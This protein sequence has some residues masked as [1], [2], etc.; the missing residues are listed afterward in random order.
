MRR[1]FLAIWVL[2]LVGALLA[3]TDVWVDRG[4]VGAGIEVVTIIPGTP[5]TLL[6]GNAAGLLRSTDG[7]VSWEEG[8][9]G[10][11][12]AAVIDLDVDPDATATVWATT[13]EGLYRSADGGDTWTAVRYWSISFYMTR[14]F[15]LD[16]R[17]SAWMYLL[18][19]YGGH[20]G[21]P[22]RLIVEKSTD[23][24]ASW[25][26]LFSVLGTCQTPA[27]AIHPLA[28]DTLYAYLGDVNIYRSTDAGQAWEVWKVGDVGAITG[29]A[30][31]PARPSWLFVVTPFN[32]YAVDP[33]PLWYDFSPG[34]LAARAL[35][36]DP[37]DPEIMC[38]AT[39]GG[40]VY[41]TA[42]CGATWEEWNSGLTDLEVHCLAGDGRNPA[43]FVAGTAHGGVF[44]YAEG[45]PMVLYEAVVPLAAHGPG[46]NGTFWRTDLHVVNGGE[47]EARL[48][49]QLLRQ[50]QANPEPERV[51]LDVPAG[52]SRRLE[53][54]LG[55][56][57]QA[58]NGALRL[59]GNTPDLFAGTRFY[60]AGPG[61]GTFGM[62]VPA[63]EKPA[64][65]AGGTSGS[66]AFFLPLAQSADPGRGYRANVGGVS[67]VDF[68]V[69]IRLSLFDAEG[70]ELGV[71]ERRLRAF[72]QFQFTRVFDWVGR[73][74]VPE[75]YAVLE[76]LTP[77]GSVHPYAILI[78]NVTGSPA[79]LAPQLRAW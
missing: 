38:A 26:G 2:G 73:P 78:D 19:Q 41:R 16:P 29:L 10:L 48:E 64:A 17:D 51:C 57:F 68:E 49:I 62:A 50:D 7:G 61:G 55:A 6:A 21:S 20:I 67:G 77:G 25:A 33:T 12:Q 36:I 24:G 54:V 15:Y 3:Q 9:T 69:D 40:G 65:L 52:R 56:S 71:L 58:T 39:A 66:R 14:R 13:T 18:V 35:L 30:V 27:L 5:L 46:L 22:P 45:T 31:N 4:P 76:V 34:Y 47:E 37:R 59:L 42:N 75:G 44:T 32:I 43:T 23:G 60:T 79:Y 8:G 28:P 63:L 74:E 72:E 1:Y 53:D 11:P 70:E